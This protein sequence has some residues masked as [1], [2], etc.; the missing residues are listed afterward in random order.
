LLKEGH[1]QTMTQDSLRRRWR[2]GVVSYLNA[3]PLVAGLDGVVELVFDVPANLPAL[4][5]SGVV[6][7]ALVPV[8]DLLHEDRS[9]RVLSDACIGCDGETLTVRVFSRVS[10]GDVSRL[11]VDGDSHT[12]V[13]LAKII[14]REVYGRPLE[15][16]PFTGRE[17][18]SECEA[19][20]L[21][22]DKVVQN[23]LIEYEIETDLGSA[24]KSLTSLPFV[25]AVWA[26][27]RGDDMSQLAGWLSDARDRGMHSAEMIA[28]D[29]APGLGWPVALAKRYLTSRLSFTLSGRHKQ[30]MSRFLELARTYD[31]VPA[32]KELIFA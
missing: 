28:A 19:I 6:D 32:G 7:A 30:G 21:I 17:T 5:D 20:L 14:W 18:V 2:I 26:T 15:V 16:V 12:S 3:K 1:N 11:H 29:F 10:P 9:W 4:L 24:W 23:T 22:G 25:F 13:M 8:V 27:P 31:L